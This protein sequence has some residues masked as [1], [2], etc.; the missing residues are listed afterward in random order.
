MLTL[1]MQRSALRHTTETPQGNF[2]CSAE[3]NTKPKKQ[4]QKK[5]DGNKKLTRH[6]ELRQKHK[7]PYA[8]THIP[9]CMTRYL[10]DWQSTERRCGG[11]RERCNYQFVRS[12]S[13]KGVKRGNSWERERHA[14]VASTSQVFLRHTSTF[15]LPGTFKCTCACV[16]TSE[17]GIK[18]DCQMYLPLAFLEFAH[19]FVHLSVSLSL[20]LRTAP[21]TCVSCAGHSLI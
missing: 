11:E 6:P 4:K 18:S 5:S 12:K 8:H 9:F 2:N 16:E 21:Q 14:R 19:L 20:H 3:K 13:E 1:N 17:G 15:H 10:W 7:M